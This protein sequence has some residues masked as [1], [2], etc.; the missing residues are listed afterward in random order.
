MS[1]QKSEQS[2]RCGIFTASHMRYEGQMALLK[3]AV[4]SVMAQARQKTPSDYEVNFS[5]HI[6]MSFNKNFKCYMD[7]LQEFCC[8]SQIMCQIRSKQMYQLEHIQLL[9][10][11]HGHKYDMIMF[12]D[13][14]DTYDPFRVV[15]FEDAMRYALAHVS[16]RE[17]V[18]VRELIDDTDD[19]EADL[20]EFWAY[21]VTP[22]LLNAFFRDVKKWKLQSFVYHTMGDMVLRTYLRLRKEVMVCTFQGSKKMYNYNM[23]NPNGICNSNYFAN[24]SVK[25]EDITFSDGILW[26][27]HAWSSPGKDMIFTSELLLKKLKK[28][29][30]G[31]I[32][33]RIMVSTVEKLQPLLDFYNATRNPHMKTSP[34]SVQHVSTQVTRKKTRKKARK[35]RKKH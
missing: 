18:C 11:E 28:H 8:S 21:G 10:E 23:N 33:S 29:C 25:M 7:E 22:E 31:F 27:T 24:K 20:P 15:A 13:D 34:R 19:P 2:L 17:L 4:G 3:R 5:I 16:S 32:P 35:N 26:S 12:L 14:D 6:S 1:Q 9:F 30:M